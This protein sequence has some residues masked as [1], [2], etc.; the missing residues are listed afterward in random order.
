MKS[1]RLRNCVQSSFLFTVRSFE[2]SCMFGKKRGTVMGPHTFPFIYPIYFVHSY[3]LPFVEIE[4]FA[5]PHFAL[6]QNLEK[7]LLEAF[8]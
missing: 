1:N 5:S 8:P 2:G 4:L 3:S 6:V 7:V